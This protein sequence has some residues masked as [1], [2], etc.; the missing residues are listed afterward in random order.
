MTKNPTELALLARGMDT[1]LARTLRL[2]GWTLSKLQQLDTSLLEALGI[3][4]PTIA[5]LRKGQRPAIPS[6]ALIQVLFVSR[7]LCCVCRDPTRPVVVHHIKPWAQS[8][9]HSPANLAVLCTLHHGEAH[10]CRGLE[11][12]LSEE[13]LLAAKQTWEQR[14]AALDRLAIHQSTQMHECHWWYFNHLRLLELA[15]GSGVDLTELPGFQGALRHGGCDSGGLVS[16]DD[17]GRSPYNARAGHYVYR[18]MTEVLNCVLERAAP[19]NISDEMDRGT[20]PAL[21]TSGDLIILQGRYFFSSVKTPDAREDLVRGRRSANK[22]EISFVFNRNEGTSGSAR[23]LWLC[24]TQTLCSI[25]MV[26]RVERSG[27]GYHIVATVLAIRSAHG[28]LKTRMYEGNLLASGLG[29][30]FVDDSEE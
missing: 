3:N 20:L 13:R 2:A 21:I 14:T 4:S 29:F 6:E 8:R 10:N 1:D 18:Y 17:R 15:R 9:D 16:L 23:A 11:L 5:R 30:N 7:W 19:R 12:S 25:L 24:G 28:E 27:A 22:V 26:N